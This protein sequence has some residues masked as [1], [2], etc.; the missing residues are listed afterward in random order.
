MFII[1]IVGSGI[2]SRDTLVFLPSRKYIIPIIMVV[3]TQFGRKYRVVVK[4]MILVHSRLGFEPGESH[5][6][7]EKSS[8]IRLDIEG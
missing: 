2:R 1:L 3:I 6:P 8:H 4:K 5:L 7:R